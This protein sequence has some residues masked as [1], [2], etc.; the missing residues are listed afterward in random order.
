MAGDYIP[1]RTDLWDCPEVVRILSATC[2]QVVHGSSERV[3]KQS[4]IIGALY[5]TWSLF[6]TYTEDG[7]L[8]GYD[9]NTLNTMVGIEN[10]A[11]NLQ[12]VGW[13]TIEPQALVMPGFEKYLSNSAKRRL[14]DRAR[15]R[16]DRQEP[17]AK[18]PQSVHNGADKMR[19]IEEKRIE[20]KNT[21]T[22]RV[23]SKPSLEELSAYCVE[24]NNA[25]DPQAFLDHYTANGWRVGKS[26]M[27]DWR[28]SVRTWERHIAERSKSEPRANALPF[29]N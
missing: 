3:R 7:I 12:H 14:K 22:G 24:R 17:S 6:D 5:R 28:A 27:K 9:S 15:K 21:N 11:E 2:P 19:T 16:R 26:P 10:W 13:L 8:H 25:V 1:M 4:E 23:F 18:R 29:A 20:E